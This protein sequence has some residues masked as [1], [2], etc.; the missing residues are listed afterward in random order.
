MTDIRK[1]SDWSA[2]KSRKKDIIRK[3]GKEIK[4]TESVF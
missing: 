3:K 2:K 1:K 4:L